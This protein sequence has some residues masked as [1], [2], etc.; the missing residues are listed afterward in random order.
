MLFANICFHFV[1]CLYKIWGARAGTRN[2]HMLSKHSTTDLHPSLFH[3]LDN[4]VFCFLLQPWG[5][6]LGPCT[7]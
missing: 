1:S 6:N 7:C 3:C 5:L 2:L 4:V